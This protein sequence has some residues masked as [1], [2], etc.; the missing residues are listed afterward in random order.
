[1]SVYQG[2]IQYE[3]RQKNLKDSENSH[4]A[5]RSKIKITSCIQGIEVASTKSGK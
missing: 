4:V 5:A 1:M 2:K 3:K